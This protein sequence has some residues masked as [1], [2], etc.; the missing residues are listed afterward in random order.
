MTIDDLLKK[1]VLIKDSNSYNSKTVEEVKI[2]EISPSKNWTKLMNSHGNSYWRKTDDIALIEVLIN[3]KD[4][5]P[6]N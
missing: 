6:K 4:G 5:K 3:L 2:L 1:R